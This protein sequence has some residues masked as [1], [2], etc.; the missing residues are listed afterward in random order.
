[1]RQQFVCLQI[2]LKAPGSRKKKKNILTTDSYE[3]V[4]VALRSLLYSADIAVIPAPKLHRI[5]KALLVHGLLDLLCLRTEEWNRNIDFLFKE[6][7]ARSSQSNRAEMIKYRKGIQTALFEASIV[8]R[9]RRSVECDPG[10]ALFAGNETKV[11]RVRSSSQL[12]CDVA[13]L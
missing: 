4:N 1:M 8:R 10:G 13:V 6:A 2:V 7:K 3:V 9:R 11:R 5:L 12:G